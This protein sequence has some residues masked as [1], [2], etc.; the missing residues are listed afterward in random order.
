MK[1]AIVNDIH[2]GP[3]LV[4]EGKTRAFSPLAEE[5]L[6]ETLRHIEERHSPD[7]FINLGDLIRS[8]NREI[9]HERYQRIIQMFHPYH[10]LHLMGNHELRTLQLEEV[11]TLSRQKTFGLKEMGSHVIIWLGLEFVDPYLQL[12]LELPYLTCPAMGDN[13]CAPQLQENFPEIYTILTADSSNITCKAYSR[14]F[15]FAGVEL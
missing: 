7:L 8:E 4:V 12:P 2:A 5:K 1:I 3:P 13:I 15:C 11:E 6:P 9:D 10:V 14:D